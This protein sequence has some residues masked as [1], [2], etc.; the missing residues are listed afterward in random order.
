MHLLLLICFLAFIGTATDA[1]RPPKIIPGKRPVCCCDD[2]NA[3]LLCVQPTGDN[4]PEDRPDPMY[5]SYGT[6]DCP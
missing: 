2:Y 4:C 5:F 6:P 1:R 3:T